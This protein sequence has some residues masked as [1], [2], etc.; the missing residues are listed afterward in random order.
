MRKNRPSP[1]PTDEELAV[2][3]GR[4]VEATCSYCWVT[5]DLTLQVGEYYD[6]EEDAVLCARCET[7]FSAGSSSMGQ[8]YTERAAD[9]LSAGRVTR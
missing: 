9:L 3:F 1:S 5:F 6:E 4:V 7:G 8:S 2:L